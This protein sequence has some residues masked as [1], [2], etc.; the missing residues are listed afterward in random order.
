[1]AS[2]R[3]IGL[4]AVRNSLAPSILQYRPKAPQQDEIGQLRK[5]EIKRKAA[6]IIPDLTQQQSEYIVDLYEKKKEST[7]MV[8]FMVGNSHPTLKES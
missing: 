1:M 6:Q 2:S 5:F 7:K 3:M 8:V 4:A